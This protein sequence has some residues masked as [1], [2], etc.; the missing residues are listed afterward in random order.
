M[1]RSNTMEEMKLCML[2]VSVDKVRHFSLPPRV[3]FVVKETKFFFHE[4]MCVPVFVYVYMY[5]TGLTKNRI[6]TE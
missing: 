6:L 3:R 4:T 1:D 5:M 2:I